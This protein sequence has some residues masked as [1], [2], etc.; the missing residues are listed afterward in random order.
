MWLGFSLAV[1]ELDALR[2]KWDRVRNF[3][4][5]DLVACPQGN[6]TAPSTVASCW[7][8]VAII[9]KFTIVVCDRCASIFASCLF[10]F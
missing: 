1:G 5:V 2:T 10:F 8:K 7:T 9:D 3:L 4:G 6:A